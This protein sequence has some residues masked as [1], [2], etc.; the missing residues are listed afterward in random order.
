MKRSEAI[1][2]LDSY[3][4]DVEQDTNKVNGADLLSFI[5]N[6]LG[7]QP[8]VVPYNDGSYWAYVWEEEEGA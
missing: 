3:I 1:E 2:C 7:M 5:E 6:K 4:F 8:P